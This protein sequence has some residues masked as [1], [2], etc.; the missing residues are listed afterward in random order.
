VLHPASGTFQPRH[1]RGLDWK[2][3][4]A[5]AI[6]TAATLAFLGVGYWLVYRSSKIACAGD[7]ACARP[8]PNKLVK[9]TLIIAT[10]LVIAAWSFD[11]VA[12]YVLS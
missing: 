12:P 3:Y 5:R 1:R 4:A 8:L 9:I 7:Q 10:I 2:L 11:Y 6:S